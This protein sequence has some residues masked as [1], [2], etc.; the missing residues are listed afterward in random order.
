M[1]WLLTVFGLKS[2]FQHQQLIT[3]TD[4][5]QLASHP[6][7]PDKGSMF[8]YSQYASFTVEQMAS[9]LGLGG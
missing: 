8:P 7:G 3:I 1:N 4:H 6:K 9:Q 2:E 5:G